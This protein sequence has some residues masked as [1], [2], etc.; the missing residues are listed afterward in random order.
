MLFHAEPADEFA[1]FFERTDRFTLGV[2][3]GC[4]MLAALKSLVPGAGHW[5]RFIRNRGE[6]FE[7]RFSLVEILE[8]PAALLEGMAGSRL[9]IAVAHGEGQ[10]RV[11]NDA[12]GRGTHRASSRSHFVMWTTRAHRH[13]LSGQSQWFAAGHC[14]DHQR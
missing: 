6:Q 14:R 1:G 3:N 2:C 4:Q 10:G 7:G 12:G 9:P 13:H 11:C 5:P 8:S